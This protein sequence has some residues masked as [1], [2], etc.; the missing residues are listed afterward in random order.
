MYDKDHFNNIIYENGLNGRCTC[1][2]PNKFLDANIGYDYWDITPE[3]WQG[4]PTDLSSI[5]EYFDKIPLLFRQ[6]RGFYIYGKYG[7]GK[8][9]LACML[10]KRVIIDTDYSALFVP[11]SEL[12]MLN[13]K[14]MIG[15]H[16][17]SVELAI[18]QIKNIDFLVL[19]DL[20]KE[21]DNER[22]NGRATLNTILRYRD[23]WRKP[24]I[25]TANIPLTETQEKYGASNFSIIRG[26]ST[27]ISMES[28]SDFRAQR[29]I[30]Q[31]LSN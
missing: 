23:L 21:Y 2:V 31:E 13:S 28:D 12:V 7:T 30:L 15:W 20:A 16:D 11:F 29:K 1:Y 27:I 9:S 17:A 3:N 25:Y 19:D 10:L 22:D 18:N 24:T 4:K 14:I 26:R 8:T 6:G 5:S